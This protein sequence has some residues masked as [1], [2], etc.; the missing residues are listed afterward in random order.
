MRAIGWPTRSLP[1]QR[2]Q[3]RGVAGTV[4]AAP[5][6]TRRVLLLGGGAHARGGGALQQALALCEHSTRGPAQRAWTRASILAASDCTPATGP[7]TQP[8]CKPAC[9]PITRATPAVST[10]RPKTSTP[11]GTPCG[12]EPSCALAAPGPAPRPPRPPARPRGAQCRQ[13][14]RPR[15]LLS[16]ACTAGASS[17]RARVGDERA[18]H[19]CPGASLRPPSPRPS[20]RCL[21]TSP[22]RA[23]TMK[24]GNTAARPS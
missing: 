12:T 24:Q 8:A 21:S 4:A 14:P 5:A 17:L 20:P 18:H 2:F 9:L 19:T 7:P 15:T 22:T 1:A 11:A 16:T 23:Y 13:T 10:P 3:P 6:P